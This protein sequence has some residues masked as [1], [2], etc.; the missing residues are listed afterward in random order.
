MASSL[1]NS[2]IQEIGGAGSMFSP[3]PILNHLYSASSSKH[4]GTSPQFFTDIQDWIHRHGGYFHPH[5]ELD[6]NEKFN[7]WMLVANEDIEQGTVLSKVPWDLLIGG[8]SRIQ[9]ISFPSD[10]TADDFLPH[11]TGYLDCESIL[12]LMHEL[13]LGHASNFGPY[14]QYLKDIPSSNLPSMWSEQGKDILMDLLGG[15]DA[16]DLPPI[17]PLDTVRHDWLGTCKGTNDGLEA[18]SLLS[19][20]GFWDTLMAPTLDWYTHRNGKYLNVEI[21]IV[22]GH[23]LEVTALRPIS[24]GETLHRSLDLCAL[25]NDE[26]VESGYGTPGRYYAQ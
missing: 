4:S 19:R 6:Y 15:L 26:A 9:G 12:Q 13:E 2:L 24:K 11:I 18:A 23:Y 14:V 22:P 20:H 3:P 7:G 25:C 5:Q 1:Q 10:A 17:G 8:Y 21:Q 16:G